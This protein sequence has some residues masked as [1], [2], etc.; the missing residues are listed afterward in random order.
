MV[1]GG[2]GGGLNPAWVWLG[3]CWKRGSVVTVIAHVDLYA[4]L[5]YPVTTPKEWFGLLVG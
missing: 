3:D 2:A 5:S 4:S 1:F